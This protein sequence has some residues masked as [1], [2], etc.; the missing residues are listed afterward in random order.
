MMATLGSLAQDVNA[1]LGNR[2]DVLTYTTFP[3]VPNMQ[4]TDRLAIWMKEA[5]TEICL[6]YRFEEL[7]TSVTDSFVPS[8]DTYQLPALCRMLRAVTLLFGTN[9][10]PRPVRR[11]HIRNIRRYQTSTLGPPAI[12]APFNP[13]GQPSIIVRPVPDQG[14]PLI[15]DIVQK[16]TFVVGGTNTIAQTTIQLP[17]DWVDILKWSVIMRGHTALLERDK[18]QAIQT[19]LFGGYDPALGRKVPGMIRQRIASRDQVD[20]EDVEFGLQPQ[21][22]RYGNTP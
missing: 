18:A 4:D 11:R 5:Y 17:D 7:E 21:I 1:V 6:G 20:I 8:I 13:G 19:L 22:R 9:Q 16:P 15:W 10:Q 14:Y 3:T 12:Y 2:Q